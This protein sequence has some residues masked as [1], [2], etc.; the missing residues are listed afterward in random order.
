MILYEIEWIPVKR[1]SEGGYIEIE[2][3]TSINEA[4]QH[5]SDVCFLNSLFALPVSE[6]NYP[7]TCMHSQTSLKFVI[8]GYKTIDPTTF[9][10]AMLKVQ[11][12]LKNTALSSNK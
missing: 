6:A 8:R 10:G 7:L 12:F 3:D 11:F 1:Y 9:G 2:Y 5:I 4:V